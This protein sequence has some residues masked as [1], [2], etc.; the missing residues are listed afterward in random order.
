M[1]ETYITLPD[2]KVFVKYDYYNAEHETGFNHEVRI[3]EIHFE[4]DEDESYI[5]DQYK[6]FNEILIEEIINKYH[7]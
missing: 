6:D 1:Q 5:K 7:S 2:C 3:R 4:S